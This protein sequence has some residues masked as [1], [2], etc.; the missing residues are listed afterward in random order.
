VHWVGQPGYRDAANQ[1][2]ANLAIAAKHAGVRRIVYL[3]G[4]VPEADELSGHLSSRAEV[5]ESL[6]V[7]GGAEAV[8]LGHAARSSPVFG[9]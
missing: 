3:G 8:W 7:D 1:A 5:A 9:L 2:A 6:T 4:F